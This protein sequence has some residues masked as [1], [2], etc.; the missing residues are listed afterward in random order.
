MNPLL[1][2]KPIIEKY[3]KL[4]LIYRNI[5][6][7]LDT[8]KAS[9]TTPWGFK[10]SGNDEM[11]KGNFEP[12]QTEIVRRMLPNIDIFINIGANVGYYCCHALSMGKQVIAFEPIHTNISYLGKNILENGWDA[13]EIFPLALSSKPS[14]LEI[15]GANTGASLIKGWANTSEN[16]KQL[17][18]ATKLDLVLGTRL[19]GLKTLILVDIEGAE[20]MMLDGAATILSNDPAPIW[21]LEITSSELQPSGV[22]INPNFKSTFGLF[23]NCG[24]KAYDLENNM[25]EVSEQFVLD[26]FMQKI[27]C[28]SNNF[29][30]MKS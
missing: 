9:V 17:I 30:F 21:I 6:D 29:V 8:Y 1:I 16:Y 22:G 24:Y 15:Y 7:Q 19:H 18:P 26:V 25:T 3:P 2:L 12:I 4:S 13:I 23:F 5:R 27:V 11:A 20:K 10:F 28:N 14:V